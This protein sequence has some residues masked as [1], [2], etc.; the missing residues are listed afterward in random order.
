MS[1]LIE[2]ALRQRVFMVL[3]ALTV[4]GLGVKSYNELPIDA[5][6]DISPT[7]VKMIM[8]SEGM[9]PSK[10]SHKLPYP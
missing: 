4:L 1:S 9:T 6:P 7:Q 3:L 8:K 10:L 5:F 2:F